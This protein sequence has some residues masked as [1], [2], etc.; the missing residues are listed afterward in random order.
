MSDQTIPPQRPGP[1]FYAPTDTPTQPAKKPP[2]TVQLRW[3]VLAAVTIGVLSCLMGVASGGGNDGT[4]RTLVKISPSPVVSIVTVTAAPAAPA[5]PPAPTTP[6]A[7][8]APTI[9]SGTWTVGTD[10]PAGTYRTE[11]AADNCFWSIYKAGTNQAEIVQNHIGGG[12]LSVT[13]KQGQEFTSERCG[14]WKKVG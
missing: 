3:A 11:G 7:P 10:F 14:T 1:P 2:R 6:P 8:A 13:L 5:Q 4:S 9:K 12:N